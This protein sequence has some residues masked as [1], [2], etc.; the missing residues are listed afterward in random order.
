MDF[1]S[2]L[3]RERF[4][5]HEESEQVI[6]LS[7]RF[8]MALFNTDGTPSEFYVV[9]SQT[10]HCA[11]RMGAQ[12]L[13]AFLESGP[14]ANR[15]ASFDWAETWH[16]IV[17]L[18]ERTF[19]Q[20]IWVSVYK[21]GQSVFHDGTIHPFLNI[22]EQCDRLN[23]ENYEE[24]IKIAEN[25]FKKL[26]KNV[27][28]NHHLMIGLLLHFTP[29]EARCGLV[30]RGAERKGTFNFT[31]TQKEKKGALNMVHCLEVCA[32]YLEAIQ[33]S[34][35]IGAYN[36]KQEVGRLTDSQQDG[37]RVKMRTAED[38]VRRLESS[39][40]SFESLYNVRYRPEKPA[41][42]LFITEAERKMRDLTDATGASDQKAE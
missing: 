22:I 24:T 40:A 11:L 39:I 3:Y 15:A 12:I 36:E 31:I 30:S 9:R 27:S 23:R 17:A 19:N 35:E 10:M 37:M 16:N 8:P 6:A 21:D 2:T 7:N 42:A 1:H 29:K 13:K 32:D 25:A 26:G 20:K 14:L 18:H 41:F 38:R 34:F 33:L 28:I 5:I 4:L